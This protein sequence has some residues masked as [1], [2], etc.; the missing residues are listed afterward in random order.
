MHWDISVL[1][2][3]IPNQLLLNNI[4]LYQYKIT[5]SLRAVEKQSPRLLRRFSPRNDELI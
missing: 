3:L 4:S 1:T 2:L 5:M